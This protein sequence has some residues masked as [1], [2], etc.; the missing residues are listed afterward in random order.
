VSDGV[1]RYAYY[2]R[3]GIKPVMKTL[4]VKQVRRLTTYEDVCKDWTSPVRERMRQ[5][6]WRA[7]ALEPHIAQLG[8]MQST[9]ELMKEAKASLE[10]HVHNGFVELANLKE[11]YSDPVVDIFT[12][13]PWKVFSP[14]LSPSFWVKT[15]EGQ[16]L[17]LM[18]GDLLSLGANWSLISE[19]KGWF[20]CETVLCSFSQNM[21]LSRF[22]I[23]NIYPATSEKAQ[24]IVTKMGQVSQT[25]RGCR[26]FAHIRS[27]NSIALEHFPEDY[28]P[29]KTK[30]MEV[31]KWVAENS[32]E[33]LDYKLSDAA[34]SLTAAVALAELY[35]MSPIEAEAVAS[36]PIKVLEC[37]MQY[38]TKYNVTPNMQV[39]ALE[40][41]MKNPIRIYKF[42]GDLLHKGGTT[43][44]PCKP[45]PIVQSPSGMFYPLKTL[46][47]PSFASSVT[48]MNLLEIP[49]F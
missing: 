25:V 29:M 9:I 8:V 28:S 42:N 48:I 44:I 37:S 12:D 2:G 43:P 47:I 41:K 36:D 22:K 16:L 38:Q 1:N 24:E 4:V 15:K 11:F 40:H 32:T 17:E 7:M 3:L 6:L 45:V 31:A 46:E 39:H 33:V 35:M 10:H 49:R 27:D 19:F 5:Q 13:E 18:Y 26:W 21:N 34:L 14:H 30:N 23:V 20:R